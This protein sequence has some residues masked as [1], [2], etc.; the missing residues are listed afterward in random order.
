MSTRL[1]Q[2]LLAVLGLVAVVF[3]L[4]GVVLGADGVRA[5]GDVSPNVDSE[6]RYFA[7][8]YAGAGLLLLHSAP[9]VQAARGRLLV[10]CLVL[11]L[12]AVG[13]VLSWHSLGRPDDL[14]V[15][16]L[17]VELAVAAVVA[18]WVLAVTSRR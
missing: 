6:L 15:G 8:W 18:P 5:G 10:L 13:R 3:G 12:G 16:L 2:G 17:V 7:A 11:L 4:T 1:L 9:R 14:F